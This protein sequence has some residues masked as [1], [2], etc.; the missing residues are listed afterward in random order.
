MVLYII[1]G[2]SQHTVTIQLKKRNSKHSGRH[3]RHTNTIHNHRPI[4]RQQ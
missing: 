1:A 4:V 2:R 3:Y